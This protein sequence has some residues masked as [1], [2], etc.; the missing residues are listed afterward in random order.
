MTLLAATRAT[1][2]R[3]IPWNAKQRRE[4]AKQGRIGARIQLCNATTNS[5]MPVQE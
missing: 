3:R 1:D 2:Y 4:R 5:I